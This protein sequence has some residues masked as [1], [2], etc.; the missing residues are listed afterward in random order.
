MLETTNSSLLVAD[1]NPEHIR[2]LETIL[3][4]EGY[5]ICVAANGPQA[6]DAASALRPDLIML[7]IGLP[8]MDGFEVCRRL[9]AIPETRQIPI[10]FLS[11]RAATEDVVKGFE[12]GAV[13]YVTKPYKAAELMARVRTQA[14]LQRANG[15]VREAYDNLQEAYNNLRETQQKLVEAERYKVLLEAAGG[16]AHE[17]NQPLQAITSRLELMALDMGADDPVRAE[18]ESALQDVQSISAIL[19]KMR[20]IRRYSSTPYVMGSKIIDFDAASRGDDET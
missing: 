4:D 19:G 16:A 14:E 10:I 13:D 11:T 9:K 12:L 18:L 20:Q 5:L 3:K 7:D 1:G 8:E 15:E 17:I 6:L 2:E